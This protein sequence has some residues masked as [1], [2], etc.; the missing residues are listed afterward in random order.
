MIIIGNMH[1]ICR[2]Q[3]EQAINSVKHSKLITKRIY[4]NKIHY[5][6]YCCN[7]A[8]WN[9]YLNRYYPKAELV[10]ER[11]HYIKK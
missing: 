7:I 9:W 10:A 5:K 3:I 1:V 11:I 6:Y 4:D 8:C 2:E